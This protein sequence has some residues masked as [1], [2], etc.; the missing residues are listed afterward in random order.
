[1]IHMFIAI[2]YCLCLFALGTIVQEPFIGDFQ[3]MPFD[4]SLFLFEYRQGKCPLINLCLYLY[5]VDVELH[6]RSECC[7]TFA[8]LTSVD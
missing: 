1:M 3:G 8:R 7:T 6:V 5:S 2:I 4:E